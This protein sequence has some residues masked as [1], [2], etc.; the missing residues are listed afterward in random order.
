[1]HLLCYIQ[2]TSDSEVGCERGRDADRQHESEKVSLMQILYLVNLSKSMLVRR[3]Y[4]TT[5]K[6]Y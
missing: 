3:Q 2:A 4:V 1:M 5:S 6:R